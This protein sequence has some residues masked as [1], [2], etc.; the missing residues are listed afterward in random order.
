[1]ISLGAKVQDVFIPY[2]IEDVIHIDKPQK[3]FGAF[4]ASGNLYRFEIAETKTYNAAWE[5]L[6]ELSSRQRFW[7]VK[8]CETVVDIG[9]CFGS[10]TLSALAD[11]ARVFSFEP[12]PFLV[13]SMRRSIALN[14][15][16]KERC[17]IFEQNAQT[18]D[19]SKIPKIDRI[20]IDVEGAEEEVVKVVA[21]K[22]LRDKP[23]LMLELHHSLNVNVKN[24]SDLLTNQKPKRIT[25]ISE[26]DSYPATENL[27]IEF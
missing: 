27:V 22:I 1:M 24:I 16:F 25:K 14:H 2:V 9:A 5:H 12:D 17:K 10:Y 19:F 26:V 3:I 11:G 8:P 4:S 18:F 15:G 21:E 23:L 20:K 6:H 7:R 13:R